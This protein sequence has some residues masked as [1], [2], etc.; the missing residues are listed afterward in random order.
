MALN[1]AA[2][3]VDGLR[4]P[5]DEQVPSVQVATRAFAIASTLTHPA[6]YCFYIALAEL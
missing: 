2:A 5:F 4:D 1:L 3:M 6:Y